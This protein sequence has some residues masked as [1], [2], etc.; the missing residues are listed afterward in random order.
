MK[1][2]I[3]EE[4]YFFVN[5]NKNMKQPVEPIMYKLKNNFGYSFVYTL[6][7]KQKIKQ[8][9]LVNTTKLPSKNK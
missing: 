9:I 7:R 5:K 3:P 1:Q 2:F 6:F 8:F 4:K